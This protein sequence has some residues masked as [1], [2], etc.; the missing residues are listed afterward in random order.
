MRTGDGE[1]LAAFAPV[2]ARGDSAAAVVVL[3]PA[4]VQAGIDSLTEKKGTVWATATGVGHGAPF[5]RI[6][7]EKTRLLF[8]T[9]MD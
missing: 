6:K 3:V 7:T 1:L 2:D 8:T 4:G 5:T 9:C